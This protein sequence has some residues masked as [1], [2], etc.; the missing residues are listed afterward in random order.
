M[1]MRKFITALAMVLL[2]V[3]PALAFQPPITNNYCTVTGTIASLNQFTGYAY[4]NQRVTFNITATGAPACPGNANLPIAASSMSY[5]TDSTGNLPSSP[6]VQLPQGANG[7]TMSIADGPTIAL[8]TIPCQTSCP[9][10]TIVPPWPLPPD[11]VTDVAV[12]GPLFDGVTVQNPAPGTYGTA[13]IAAPPS[14]PV[15]TSGP[16]LTLYLVDHGN[17]QAVTLNG[18]A[19]ITI[20]DSQANPT[21]ALPDGAVIDIATIEGAAGGFTPTFAVASGGLVW[22]GGGTQ[23]TPSIVANTWSMWEFYV[24]GGTTVGTFI[25]SSGGNSFMPLVAYGIQ[26]YGLITNSG[27]ATPS[28]PAVANVGTTGSTSYTYFVAC[29]DPNGGITEPSVAATTS[30]GNAT[31][32]STNYNLITPVAE[33]GCVSWDVL[34]G[35]TSFSIGTISTPAGSLKDTGQ[36]T[37]AYTPQTH[38]NTADLYMPTGILTALSINLTNP[39]PPLSGGTG[40]A[41][42]PTIGELLYGSNAYVADPQAPTVTPVGI[43]GSTPYSYF[44]VC[45]NAN[46]RTL[47][48]SAGTTVTGNATLSGSN[49]N[50]IAWVAPSG[51]TGGCDVLRNSVNA[52]VALA[53]TSPYLDTG[54]ATSAYTP[55]AS[56]TTGPGAYADLPANTSTISTPGAPTI[57]NVGTAGSTTASYYIVCHDSNGGSTVPSAA[58]TTTTGNAVLDATNYNSIAWTFPTGAANCD[59]LKNDTAHSLV[60]G[61]TS[62]PVSDTGQGLAAYSTPLINNSG[63]KEFLCETGSGGQGNIPAWCQITASDIGPLLP[64]ATSTPTP[65][66]TTLSAFLSFPG[67]TFAS[68]MSVS[69]VDLGGCFALPFQLTVGHFT[70]EVAH[71]GQTG[72]AYDVGLY[73]SSGNLLFH[74]GS[75]TPITGGAITTAVSPSVVLTPGMYCTAAVSSETAATATIDVI[76]LPFGPCVTG[77]ASGCSGSSCSLPATLTF[78]ATSTGCANGISM[79]LGP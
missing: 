24:V 22:N 30:T 45:R 1:A 40:L 42:N 55:P 52:S 51:A 8:A 76:G 32:D 63:T 61:A 20:A 41:Q 28:A 62:S 39:L 38:N 50:K 15:T 46:G 71:D 79:G 14:Y 77:T 74:T 27:L 70:F 47:A 31:L 33:T 11:V 69:A 13:T 5:R 12:T 75:V 66:P 7:V 4:A 54:G 49:Y 78:N 17:L 68:V 26:D 25:G 64:T 16:T 58:G 6:A 29:H 44:I 19:T 65:A 53:T 35:N 21:A 60:L 73:N 56:N 36:A 9:I 43:L 23:P 3:T 48:S 37:S 72:K 34:K 57:T 10:T 18:N 2:S 59:V 67:V